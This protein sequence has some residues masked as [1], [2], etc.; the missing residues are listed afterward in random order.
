[1]LARYREKYQTIF[2]GLGRAMART[3]LS[4]NVF[5][6]IS[7]IPALIMGYFFYVGNVVWGLIFI[8]I[9]ALV[10]VIDGNVARATGN[11]TVFGKV[12]DHSVDRYVEFIMIAGLVS[13]GLARPLSGFVAISGMIMA[14]YVRA[15]AESE[16]AEKCDIGLM[17]RAEKLLIIMAGCIL[18]KWYASS[19]DYALLLVGA[20]SHITVIQRLHYAKRQLEVNK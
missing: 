9:S 2:S 5:T 19:I 4:P 12:F 13:G 20:L 17:D 7:L 14:S 16:G 8:V 10:D 11:V 18:F 15:K 6:A 1:M 3:G